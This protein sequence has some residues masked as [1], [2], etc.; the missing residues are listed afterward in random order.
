LIQNLMGL[1]PEHGRIDYSMDDERM[2]RKTEGDV[3]HSSKGGWFLLEGGA[4]KTSITI[5]HHAPYS[6][7]PPHSHDSDYIQLVFRGSVRI[8]RRTYEAGDIRIQ[9][10][11]S[12][13]G[14]EHVG[15]EGVVQFTVFATPTGLTPNWARPQDEEIWASSQ[16]FTRWLASGD[17]TF[18]VPETVTGYSFPLQVEVPS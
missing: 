15:P 8:G 17:W 2:V 10:A 4:G 6:V 12:V 3:D 7:I 1:T 18:P 13:Y 14:P 16:N 9:Q 5:A 11:G